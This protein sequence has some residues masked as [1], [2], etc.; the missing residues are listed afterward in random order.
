MRNCKK[1]FSFFFGL[2]LIFTIPFLKTNTAFAS[3]STDLPFDTSVSGYITDTDDQQI[4]TIN[5]K[6]AGKVTVNL[7]SYIGWVNIALEDSDGNEVF[8]Q[9]VSGGDPMDPVKRSFSEDLEAGTYYIKV[10]QESNYTGKYDLEV[11]YEAAHNNEI[12]P[13]DG[14][15]QAQPLAV[16]SQTVTGFI[17]WNDSKD[18][19]KVVLPKAGR[20]TVN[21]DSYIGWVNIALEDSNGNK[22]FDRYV[23]GDDYPVKRSF[24]E[25]LEAGTYYIKVYQESNYTGK[26]D[27]RVNYEVVP[28]NEIEPNDGT[29]QAQPLAVNSQT[30]TGFISW[31]DSKDV[32]KVVLPKAGRVTVN[33]DS[34]IGWVNI[35]LEDS[36][37][38]KVFDRYVSGDDYPVKRSF[39]EDLEAGTYYI[40]VYQESNYTGKYDLR[41]NYEVVPNNEI[42]PND[43]TV[44]AQPLAVNSQT[45]TGF[46]S[47]NDSKD[48]YKVVLPKAGRVTVNL[49]SYIGWVNIALEDSNGNKVFDRY[50][51]GDDYPVK[52][53]F[54]EDLEAGTYYIKVYQE[55]NYTGKYTLSVQCPDLLP[56]PPTVNLVSNKSN[57]VTGKTVP[58]GMVSVKINSKVYTGKSDSKG[59]FSI[60]IPTQKAGT[61]LYIT[62]KDK[63]GCT[64]KERIVVVVDR[65]PPTA[66]IVNSVTSKSKVITGKAEANSTVIAYVGSQKI[67]SAKADKY[68]KYTIKITPKK[69]GTSIKVIAVDGAGNKSAGKV[70]KVK[71]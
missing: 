38:N 29:V 48:V 35:A 43:G 3:S 50:V 5:L 62:V 16:N 42:E 71:K 9:Y 64:S 7:D 24:S 65:I 59:L 57:A 27:L 45:V 63:Y 32:Y 34:Y 10:Y 60:K 70:V 47:W 23:S 12:E 66:P 51:S 67:G 17:S 4:Y 11:N 6:Q 28:N 46:I 36:N 39:S 49:D 68:G 25:D 13:N 19:Y 20:V 21:L 1:I 58:N 30:V 22:V 26:Y 55:S 31:N 61:K 52:R 15:V 14:T 40:K 56:A 54:S 18:V 41:V 44:Q 2:A 69:A 33:L 8:D 37:G 53:S